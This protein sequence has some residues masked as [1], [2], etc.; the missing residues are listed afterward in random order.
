MKRTINIIFVTA[1][2]LLSTSVPAFSLDDETHYTTEPLV[3]GLND[4]YSP[5]RKVF[6]S[7]DEDPIVGFTKKVGSQELLAFDQILV[8]IT[9]LKAAAENPDREVR[10]DYNERA[11]ATLRMC[12]S[13]LKDPYSR[14]RNGTVEFYSLGLQE[15]SYTRSPRLARDQALLL[16]ALDL[17]LDFIDPELPLYTRYSDIIQSIWSFLDEDFY[18]S[19]FGGWFTK[20]TPVSTTEVATDTSKRL[21]DNSL[22]MLALLETNASRLGITDTILQERVSSS[23]LFFKN[24]YK[25]GQG[26]ASLGVRDGSVVSSDTYFAKDNAL[27]GLASLKYFEKTQDGT[28]LT[29]A[30]NSWSFLVDKLW[31]E[32]FGGVFGGANQFGDPII[33]GKSLED[34][35]YFSLLSVRL[36]AYGGLADGYLDYFL[37]TDK[38]I[39]LRFKENTYIFASAD[40][41]LYTSNE[42]YIRAAAFA[43]YYFLETPHLV[44]VG[45]PREA[46]VGQAVKTEVYVRTI[47]NVPLNITF[48]SDV[49]F[50]QKSILVNNSSTIR[51][52][53]QFGNNIKAGYH[54]I[55]GT[56]LLRKV[57]IQ[58]ITLEVNM[59]A[60]VR[61]P[62]GLLYLVG[63]AVLAGVII[64]VRYPPNWLKER[65]NELNLSDSV[66]PPNPSYPIQED[67]DQ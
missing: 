46:I 4:A 21:A 30:K 60:N 9:Y 33:A 38:I 26:M 6:V 42:L 23:L 3:V 25:V 27:Y 64:V 44:G 58:D 5:F 35:V 11:L 66:N 56:V 20:L 47:P 2:I 53:L 13:Y 15:D 51:L 12:T 1:L 48:T 57:K 10:E 67:D 29:E 24:H 28:F 37:Q 63:A 43:H 62:S 54:D 34:Q 18:D 61:I 36:G 8:S 32:G 65:L 7:P 22:I 49:D 39:K 14:Q 41:K 17:A 50:E 55:L 52:D 16:W 45:T 40:R 19:T 59:K 31:E